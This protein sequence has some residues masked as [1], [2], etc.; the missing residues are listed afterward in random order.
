VSFPI[1]F[2]AQLD[3]TKITTIL[4]TFMSFDVFTQVRTA[5]GFVITVRARKL[6]AFM[7]VLDMSFQISFVVRCVAALRTRMLDVQ[8]LRS[9]MDIESSFCAKN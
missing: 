8:M 2:T 1:G 7:N 3:I 5:R 4:N 9:E 6:S